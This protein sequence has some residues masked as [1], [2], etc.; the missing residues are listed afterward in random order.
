[1]P[2]SRGMFNYPNKQIRIKKRRKKVWQKHYFIR[3]MEK[4]TTDYGKEL[5]LQGFILK[6]IR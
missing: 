1:M 2:K 5:E 6:A 3:G 4:M